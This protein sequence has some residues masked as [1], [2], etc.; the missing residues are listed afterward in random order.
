[1]ATMTWIDSRTT[2]PSDTIQG[3]APRA[4]HTRPKRSMA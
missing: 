3:M 1:M 4:A 2:D